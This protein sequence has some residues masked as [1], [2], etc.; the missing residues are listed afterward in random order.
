MEIQSLAGNLATQ[1]LREGDFEAVLTRFMN[2][3][4]HP[5]GHVWLLGDESPIGYQNLELARL[6][7][8]AADAMDLDERDAIYGEIMPIFMEDLPVTFLLPQVQTHVVHRRVRG[9]SSN[10][11]PDPVWFAEHL[12]IEED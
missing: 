7:R 8:R 10:I 2:L 6:V 11:R 4:V 9:L 3:A 12:W 5:R 1:R